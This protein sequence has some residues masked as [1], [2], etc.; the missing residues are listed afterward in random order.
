MKLRL[1]STDR[2]SAGGG[3]RDGLYVDAVL[4]HHRAEQQGASIRR[5]SAKSASPIGPVSEPRALTH[6]PSLWAL[7]QSA[8]GLRG[9]LCHER[10]QRAREQ[11]RQ[12][13]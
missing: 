11:D 4:F 7:Y 13:I 2:A 5:I 12:R 1:R 6:D 10:N 9:W 3:D 8:L